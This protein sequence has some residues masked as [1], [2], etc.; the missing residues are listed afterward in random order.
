[1]KIRMM[2]KNLTKM[3]FLILLL[4]NCGLLINDTDSIIPPSTD[5]EVIKFITESSSFSPVITVSGSPE[6]LWTWNDG[7]TSV[8]TTPKKDYGSDAIRENTLKVT[9][10]SALQRINI[11]YDG[12]DGG[13]YWELITGISEA[14]V[15]DQSVSLVEGLEVVSEY[16]EKWYSSYN[17]L[18]Q[19]DFTDFINLNTIECYQSSNLEDIILSNTPSLRRL[20]I[21]QCNVESLDLSQSPL[22]EDL[23]GALNNYPT[24]D[25][26][27][28]G[29]NLWHI[30]IRDNN[31]SNSTLLNNMSQFPNIEELYIWNDNQRGTLTIPSSGTTNTIWF[32][33]N[34]NEYTVINFNGALQNDTEIARIEITNNSISQIM[35]DDCDQIS[36][37]DVRNNSLDESQV[38]YILQTLDNLDRREGFIN[39]TGNVPP[40]TSGLIYVSNLESKGWEVYTD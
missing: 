2:I 15:T 9:P 25:F 20:C 37:F 3:I 23:R 27:S 39:I 22:L 21:E 18:E 14:Y 36:Y 5:P 35:I 30:C 12:K 4:L 26:G 28:I 38:N 29:E 24:I 10:W 34:N 32:N 8:S 11:G 33:I 1:M 7:S 31:F 16:L 40:S 19:L 13:D 6:I 17:L